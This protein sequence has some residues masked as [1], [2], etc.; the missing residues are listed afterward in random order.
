M[1]CRLC[2]PG[3]LVALLDAGAY[4]AAMSSTYNMRPLA[5]EVLVDGGRFAVTRDRQSF[6]ALLAGQ[7]VPGWLAEG[8]PD[9]PAG[10]PAGRPAALGR[11][12]RLARLALWWEAVWPRAWPVLAVVGLFLVLALLD[13]PRHCRASC[14]S[15]CCWASRW[16]SGWSAGGPSAASRRP[17]RPRRNGGW[18]AHSGLRHRP[19]A[20]LADTPAGD[21][22]AALALWQVHQQRAAAQIRRLRVGTPRPGLPARDRRA[23]RAAGAGVVAAL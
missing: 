21:D 12:R 14:T 10:P 5:A 2:S 19:L 22:P 8:A 7:R 16:R 13:V 20:A 15:C 6:D 23:L 3:A 11:R 9:E 4:G 1:R 18:R 17:M